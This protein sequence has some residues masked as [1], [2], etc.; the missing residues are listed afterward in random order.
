MSFLSPVILNHSQLSF[1]GERERKKT[2]I[3]SL[4][5]GE[6]ELGKP[7]KKTPPPEALQLGTISSSSSSSFLSNNN[8][9]LERI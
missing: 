2:E 6:R 8:L 1:G 5:E 4:T 7:K 9:V 3:F